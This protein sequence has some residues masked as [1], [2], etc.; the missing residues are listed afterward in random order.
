MTSRS[1][2]FFVVLLHLMGVSNH[3]PSNL[4]YWMSSIASETGIVGVNPLSI[5]LE[6]LDL[7]HI[8]DGSSS[9]S[10]NNHNQYDVRQPHWLQDSMDANTCLGPIGFSE[11]GDATLWLLLPKQKKDRKWKQW[12][13]WATEEQDEETQAAPQGYA[14]QLVDDDSYLRN[15]AA[16]MESSSSSSPTD[17]YRNKECLTRRRKDHKLVL[18]SCS[19]DK[20]WSWQVNGEGVLYLEQQPQPPHKSSKQHQQHKRLLKKPTLDCVW[21]N[22]TEAALRPCNGQ[23]PPPT[24]EDGEQQPQPQQRVVQFALVRQATVSS[25]SSSSSASTSTLGRIVQA[26]ATSDEE[27]SSSTEE[28]RTTTSSIVQQ[29][30][31][32]VVEESLPSSRTED[33]AHA[34]A[35]AGFAMDPLLQ[36][37]ELRHSARLSIH[38]NNVNI[39]P[40]AATLPKKIKNNPKP[41]VGGNLQL[42]FLKDTNPILL[43]GGNRGPPNNNNKKNTKP[44]PTPTATVEQQRSK[45]SIKPVVL[46]KIRKHPYIEES[47]QNKWTD[48]KT[49]LQYDTDLCHY[50]G[51]DRKETGRHTLTGVGLYMR[52]VFNIKVRRKKERVLLVL[53]VI[54][55][56]GWMYRMYS[57]TLRVRH[58]H[59]VSI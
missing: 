40:N 43:A 23:V 38:V 4:P 59:Y 14:L 54:V 8:M 30:Q 22:N 33:L 18:G 13:K 5:V 58:S 24:Q 15:A 45:S 29:Q 10:N 56:R 17:N 3:L 2:R 16:N 44:I 50:L 1:A 9:N 25:S 20:A 19:N 39:D 32:V 12:I 27:K 36:L 57:N 41:R 49:G 31:A 11:C 28:T 7:E 52:T 21:R 51:D 47:K 6:T 35:H 42:Q 55:P 26:P 34:N 37:R 46:R 53:V 48:P